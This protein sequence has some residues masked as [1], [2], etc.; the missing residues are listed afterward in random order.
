MSSW[1]ETM[2]A[3][4]AVSAVGAAYEAGGV[5][6]AAVVLALLLALFLGELATAD[7]FGRQP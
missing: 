5:V 1:I 3:V 2:V 6:A 4:I 7:T